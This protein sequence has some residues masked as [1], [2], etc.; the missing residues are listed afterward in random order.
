MPSDAQHGCGS[1]CLHAEG[2]SAAV[3][4]PTSSQKNADIAVRV[5]LNDDNRR[6]KRAIAVATMREQ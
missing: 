6:Y 3:A 1:P 2:E 5:I 4:L